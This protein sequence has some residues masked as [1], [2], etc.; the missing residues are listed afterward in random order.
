MGVR[1]RRGRRR[2]KGRG[3]GR[4]REWGEGEKERGNYSEVVVVNLIVIGRI[5]K[6]VRI[7]L[8]SVGLLNL[9]SVLR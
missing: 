2:G 6:S 7:S 8:L 3:R 9:F 4:G 1:R 5:V